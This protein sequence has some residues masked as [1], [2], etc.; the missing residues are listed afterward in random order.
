MKVVLWIVGLFALALWRLAET[1]VGSHPNEPGGGDD[2]AKKAFKRLK[3]VSLAVVYLGIA[4]TAVRFA[5]GGGKSNSAQNAGL[6]AR[7]LQSGWGKAVLLIAGVGI[8]AVGGYHIYKGLSK[9]FDVPIVIGDARLQ[10]A[11]LPPAQFDI[12]VIDAFSS[13]A[14]PL[15]LLTAEAIGIYARALKP[16]GHLLAFGAPRTFHRLAVAIEDAG[17]ELRDTVAWLYGSGMPKH[18]G[19]LK[20][21]WEPI[22]V[23]RRP[24]EGSIAR[25]VAAH[26]TGLRC[27]CGRTR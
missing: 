26:G 24:L 9:K 19:A 20:P 23:A 27:R 6:T 1:V 16:G 15:H 5:S 2:G 11:K 25:N 17:F 13:D 4:M 18:A 3:S 10:I 21:A 8:I 22:I 7:M 12:L 14:I